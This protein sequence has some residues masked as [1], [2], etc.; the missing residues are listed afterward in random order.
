MGTPQ[1]AEQLYTPRAAAALMSLNVNTVRRY[2]RTGE[3]RTVRPGDRGHYKIPASAIEEW[4]TRNT[5]NPA[6]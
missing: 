5:Y 2:C 1:N 3:L 4:K 6:A